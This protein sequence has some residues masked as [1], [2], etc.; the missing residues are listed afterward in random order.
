MWVDEWEEVGQARW[1][2]SDFGALGVHLGQRAGEHCQG[3][4][5]RQSCGGSEDAVEVCVAGA[6]GQFLRDRVVVC[7]QIFLVDCEMFADRW[8]GEV[9][10]IEI[11]RYSPD[12]A[13]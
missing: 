6:G 8:V 4:A 7:E 3:L 1:W 5:D 9:E 12:A 10:H 2:L 13:S 11:D